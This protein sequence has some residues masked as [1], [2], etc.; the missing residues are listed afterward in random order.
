MINKI[1]YG[2]QSINKVDIETVSKSL[3]ERMIT[4]GSYVDKFENLCKS[5][6][7]AKFAI[8]CNSGTSALYLAFLAIGLKKNDV[9][10][11]PAINF[12]ASANM[13]KIIGAKIYFADIDYYTGQISP[14]TIHDCLKKNKI[15]KVKAIISM[16]MGGYP[17][18]IEDL[19]K[20]KKKLN[21]YLVEDAC[22]AFGAGYKIKKKKNT[23]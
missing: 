9:V 7:K 4:N 19:Y 1:Y 6:L 8:T 15:R 23:K 2:R 21:C 17:R 13:A 12:I 10:I 20:L 18:L 14:K 16:Y 22:H 3:K 11:M 5:K